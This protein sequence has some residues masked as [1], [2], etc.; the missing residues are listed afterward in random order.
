EKLA[1]DRNGPEG[2]VRWGIRFPFDGARQGFV[3][4]GGRVAQ[5]CS[6]VRTRDRVAGAGYAGYACSAHTVCRS[7]PKI[8]SAL[9][10]KACGRSRSA[11]N[12][13]LPRVPFV[14][15]KRETGALVLVPG[16]VPV[17]KPRSFAS[18]ASGAARARG[19]NIDAAPSDGENRLDRHNR[20][21]AW[22]A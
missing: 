1:G 5:P 19:V 4:V 7:F 18:H 2:R 13:R 14:P 9:S 8:S 17:A 3:Q 20:Q 12:P 6:V 16:V 10:V 11:K 15:S 21:T 22:A